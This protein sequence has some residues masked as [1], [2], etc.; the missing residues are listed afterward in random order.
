M[1]MGVADHR[2]RAAPDGRHRVRPPLSP[3]ATSRG[4]A[5]CRRP[6]PFRRQGRRRCGPNTATTPIA[7]TS[8]TTPRAETVASRD[9]GRMG[10]WTTSLRSSR[11]PARRTAVTAAMETASTSS[12]PSNVTQARPL[13]TPAPPSQAPAS[14]VPGARS[15]GRTD[16]GRD[17]ARLV[18]R[19]TRARRAD[20]PGGRSCAR[21]RGVTMQVPSVPTAGARHAHARHR[22][23]RRPRR[24]HCGS[25][26]R[27]RRGRRSRSGASGL[28]AGRPRAHGRR[29]RPAGRTRLRRRGARPSRPSLARRRRREDHSARRAR[30]PRSGVRLRV[31]RGS[32]TGTVAVTLGSV[33]GEPRGVP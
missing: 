21:R 8:A 28:G 6:P 11:R 22:V 33:P 13:P 30:S 4:R 16:D 29:P 2:G 24:G 17:E 18:R 14:S 27:D 1:G 23:R 5:L 31:A 9:R 20:S 3:V 10:G 12:R 15:I 19:R 7:A 26:D 25:G 32:S